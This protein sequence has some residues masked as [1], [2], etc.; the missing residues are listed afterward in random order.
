[1]RADTTPVRQ[2]DPIT[3]LVLA[4]LAGLGLLGTLSM[5]WFAAPAA[6][7]K[8]TDGPIEKT[9]WQVGHF[10]GTNVDGRVSGNA[11]IGSGG[12]GIVVLVVAAIAI[13]A[14]SVSVPQ[15]RK[16]AEDMLRVAG[17]AAPAAVLYLAVTH[18]GTTVPVHLHFG[19]LASFVVACFVTSCAWWGGSMRTRR[20]QAP[21]A[22]RISS[23]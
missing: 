11:A 1:V 15:I 19:A 22:V 14:L 6:S 20:K 2:L 21:R 5:P 12:K 18:S 8:T 7:T 23:S 17:W 16:P 10:F 3:N 9:A 4:V 13:L